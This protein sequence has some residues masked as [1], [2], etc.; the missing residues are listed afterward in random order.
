MRRVLAPAPVAVDRDAAWAAL[1][2]DKKAACG[3]PRLVL[4]DRPGQPRWGV[5]LPE[6]DVRRALD[7]LIA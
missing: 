1:A 6:G 5:E 7:A 4:L 2:R 3:R